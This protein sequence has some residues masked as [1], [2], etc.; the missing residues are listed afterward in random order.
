MNRPPEQPLP[1]YGVL[2]EAVREKAGL[3]RREAA[4]RAG[5]SD[6]WWR[7]VAAGW[8][9]GPVTGTADTVAAMA[10]AVGVPPERLEAEG[11]RPDA[12][13]VLRGILGDGPAPPLRA[14]PDRPLPDDGPEIA[15]LIRDWPELETI[16][17]LADADGKPYPREERWRLVRAHLD[18]M[19]RKLREMETRAERA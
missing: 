2:I 1:P 3:S 4:R 5:I 15:A 19:R 18:A 11:E 17:R 13:R 14:V 12:A 16:W 9:N 8:Q 10:R 6:A 7:Y